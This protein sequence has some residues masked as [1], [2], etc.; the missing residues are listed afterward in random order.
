M[1]AALLNELI[2]TMDS[3]VNGTNRYSA[4]LRFGHAETLMPLFALMR[5]PGCYYITDNFDTVALHWLD[6][7]VVPMAA[8]LQMILLRAKSGKHYVRFDLNERPVPLLPGEPTLYIIPW[9]SVR[10]YLTQCLPSG[11]LDRRG[12]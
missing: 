9:D 1:S 4:M 5:L 3:A 11:F 8:N 2:T 12:S 6:F 7:Q 10:E